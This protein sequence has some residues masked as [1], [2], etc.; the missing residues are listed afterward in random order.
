MRHH[1]GGFRQRQYQ[2]FIDARNNAALSAG[3]M[4]FD[5]AGIG[6]INDINRLRNLK[7]L[8]QNE[9][10]IKALK[11]SGVPPAEMERNLL[12]LSAR[13]DLVDEVLAG[14]SAKP[15][16]SNLPRATE[17]PETLGMG[18][19][20]KFIGW[21]PEG[22]A[23]KNLLKEYDLVADGAK[24]HQIRNQQSSGTC[25]LHAACGLL[26]MNGAFPKGKTLD[27][28]YVDGLRVWER[29]NLLLSKGNVSDASAGVMDV[30]DEGNLSD[31]VLDLFATRAPPL[32]DIKDAAKPQKMFQD[33]ERAKLQSELTAILSSSDNLQQKQ[34]MLDEVMKRYYGDIRIDRSVR[35]TIK[36]KSFVLLKKVDGNVLKNPPLEPVNPYNLNKRSLKKE[37]VKLPMTVDEIS[38]ETGKVFGHSVFRNADSQSLQV[39]N[40]EKVRFLEN[41]TP[42]PGNAIPEGRT[43]FAKMDGVFKRV[44]RNP[45]TGILTDYKGNPIP[46]EYRAKLYMPKE[47]VLGTTS[48]PG[49][50]HILTFRESPGYLMQNRGSTSLNLTGKGTKIEE[51]EGEIIRQLKS[52][53][54]I[55][56]SFS[57]TGYDPK[58]VLFH[59]PDAEGRHAMVIVGAK[60]N[61]DGSLKEIL[62]ANSWGKERGKEGFYSLPWNESAKKQL[63]RILVEN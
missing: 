14:G 23:R 42:I 19:F 11:K 16:R 34:K 27:L 41:L 62:V 38:E 54:A 59:K 58:G 35:K 7:K 47:E 18:G 1:V 9:E 56:A 55:Y 61:P 39:A 57:E 29:M 28:Q 3:F 32:I 43:L 46:P 20:L 45:D 44:I 48:V 5:L 52:R 8:Y 17:T 63:I 37:A 51:I 53:K 6:Q 4:I 50:N 15:A 49:S 36:G 21:N 24:N 60:L 10:L 25:A 26:E 33:A 2:A 30:L 31:D 22:A 40:Q 12:D 13:P